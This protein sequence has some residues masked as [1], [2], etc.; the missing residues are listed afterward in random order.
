MEDIY[1]AIAIFLFAVLVRANGQELQEEWKH[2]IDI[3]KGK[4]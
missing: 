3:K 4:K 2:L 1:A